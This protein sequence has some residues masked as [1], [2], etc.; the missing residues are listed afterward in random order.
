MGLENEFEVLPNLAEL[1]DHKFVWNGS[2]S[3]LR[4]SFKNKKHRVE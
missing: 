4:V 3:E 2:V 1:N